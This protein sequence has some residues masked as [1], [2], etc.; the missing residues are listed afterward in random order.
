[1]PIL[2]K[3]SFAAQT[4]LVYVTLGTL[5]GVWSGLWY[6]YLGNHPPLNDSTWYWCYGFI[7]TGLALFVIGLLLGQIGR[8]ARHAELPPP[9]V[10]G[11][12]VRAEENAAARAPLIAPVNPVS[13][14]QAPVAQLVPAAIAAPRAALEPRRDDTAARKAEKREAH[15]KDTEPSSPAEGANT[16]DAAEDAVLGGVPA[17]TP[18]RSD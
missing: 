6:W 10:T 9:E 12:A 8:S 1:M 3:S 7:L 15:E 11:A 2:S 4:A 14:G 5:T 18:A 17:H 13:A 16:D